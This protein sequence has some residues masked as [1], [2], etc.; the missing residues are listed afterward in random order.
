MMGTQGFNGQKNGQRLGITEPISLG[1]PTEYDVI[2]TKELEEFLAEAGLYESQE[3]A[4]RREEVLGRLDQIV[5]I[6]VKKVSRARGLNE[7]LVQEANAKIFTFGSYRLGVHG[8]GADIDTLCVGPRHADRDEDFF[9]ELKRMLL[10]MPDVTELHPVPDAHVPVM[11]FKL[12]GVSIDLLYA[13]LS[14][15]VIPDDLDISQDSILQN[16][17]DKTVRSLNGCRVTDQILSLVPNIQN[18]RTTLRC[19]RFWAKRRGVYSN[20]AGFLGGINWAL[21]VGR[22]CQLYPNAVPN[23][24]V[25][26]FFRVYT[27][28]RW[29]NP[30]MLCAIEEGS[31]GLQIWDPRKN[32]K[33]KYHLMPIITPAYPSM[34][35]SYNV[36]SSTLRIMTQEFKRGHNVCEAMVLNNGSWLELFE[37]YRFFEAYK[38]YLQI[39]IVAVCEEDMMNWKGWVESRIRYL[40]LKIERDTFKL[41]L[42]HPHP[43]DFPDKSN[44][45]HCSYFLGL[46]RKEGVS[47]NDAKKF[48]IRSTVDE[49][50]G[51][52]GSYTAWK[53]GMG[54]SVTHIRRRDIPAFV[55]PGGVRPARPARASVEERRNVPDTS[56]ASSLDADINVVDRPAPGPGPGPDDDDTRKRQQED[57]QELPAPKRLSTDVGLPTEGT[58]VNDQAGVKTENNDDIIN[59]QLVSGETEKLATDSGLCE[60]YQ[61][62]PQQLEELDSFQDKNLGGT[63]VNESLE[64]LEAPE[65]VVPLPRAAHATAAAQRKPVIRFN[66]TSLANSS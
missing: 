7:Q 25:C 22:I 56:A 14:L 49:F 31:L 26:R 43:G 28:W 21:L 15:W 46:Q 62:S 63:S 53:P 27:Q 35:S 37:P 64:E 2:K 9:G 59:G 13:R 4:I 42:C 32:P 47:V 40:V 48:D 57:Y 17:D 12:N 58:N 52:V 33:D 38:N 8:P 60:S 29:P 44:P 50:K 45:F 51:N 1:G 30:V 41:L 6:W 5:K 23:M 65:L 36:S 24:L 61:S 19:M 66:F 34:N 55:F 3:E 11:R 18:F 16:A 10:E 20:V 54:I 39:D